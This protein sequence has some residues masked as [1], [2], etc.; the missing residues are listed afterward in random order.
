MDENQKAKLNID[1]LPN[2]LENAYRLAEDSKLVRETLGDHVFEKLIAN[3]KIEWD[4]YRI[5]VG[6]FEIDRYLPML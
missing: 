5:H 4:N 1:T 3:K 2:S 6:G